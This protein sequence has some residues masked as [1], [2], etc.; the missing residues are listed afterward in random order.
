MQNCLHGKFISHCTKNSRRAAIPHEL[1]QELKHWRFLDEWL[2]YAPWRQEKHLQLSLV[3]DVSSFRYGISLMSGKEKGLSFGD[4][5]ANTDDRLI[6][7]KEA[8]AVIIALQP[9]EAKIKDRRLDVYVDNTAVLYAC[10]N[11]RSKD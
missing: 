2:G 4:F 7:L 5:W 1:R 8:S 11:Q 6:Y 3:T 10:E 9:L